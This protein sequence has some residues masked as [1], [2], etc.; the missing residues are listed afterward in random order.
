MSR[1]DEALPDGV[2]VS[3]R[4]RLHREFRFVRLDFLLDYFE[5]VF[6][7]GAEHHCAFDGERATSFR[8]AEQNEVCSAPKSRLEAH[9]KSLEAE[10][11]F[12]KF[13]KELSCR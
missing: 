8:R 6:T 3:L 4:S 12:N 2:C 7:A 5:R 9:E 10:V 13:D 11:G 1:D